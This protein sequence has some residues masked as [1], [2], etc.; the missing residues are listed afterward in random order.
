MSGRRAQKRGLRINGI[1]LLDKPAGIS[2]NQALQQV[3]RLFGAAKAGH[4][5]SLDPFATGMLPICFGEASKTAGFMLDAGKTY[6]ASARLGQATATGDTE[7]EVVSEKAVPDLSSAQIESAFRSFTGV[8]E[9]VPPMYSAL[10]HHGKPL[11]E[12]A[13]AG[14]EVERKPRKVRIHQLELVSWD[15]PMLVFRVRCSK[16]TYVRTLAEDLALA[17]GSCAHL[18]ELRRLCVEPFAE[19]DMVTIEELETVITAGKQD[20]CLL[21]LDA[22]LVDWPLVTVDEPGE[23]RFVH[24]NPVPCNRSSEG[25][26]RVYS[27]TGRP[28]GLGEIRADGRVHSKRVFVGL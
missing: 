4:T 24:G 25:M 1:V 13:R 16:G 9:Q 20:E 8:I 6:L 12:L 5:G 21:P 10:K 14:K 2:S 18:Q 17:L 19:T 15:H 23:K 27:E 3:K 26:V 28:L 11:Y 7:G 22:G